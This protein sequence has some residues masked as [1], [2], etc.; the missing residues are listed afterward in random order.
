VVDEEDFEDEDE[1]DIEVEIDEVLEDD[2][3][4]EAEEDEV[5]QV[6]QEDDTK[7]EI[8]KK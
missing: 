4:V 8:R 2:I 5:N 1:D 6:L 7:V 3:E